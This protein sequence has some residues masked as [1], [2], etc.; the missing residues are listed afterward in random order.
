MN[1]LASTP[2][3]I[4]LR[5][6]PTLLERSPNFKL[7]YY[8]IYV[9]N[10]RKVYIIKLA[11]KIKLNFTS[12]PITMPS[13]LNIFLKSSAGIIGMSVLFYL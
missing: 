11:K 4:I 12:F 13:P 8:P 3:I 7:S 2:F 1:S 5:V 10:L 6:L 9:M